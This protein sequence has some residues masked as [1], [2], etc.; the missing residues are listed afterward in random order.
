MRVTV[1]P[2]LLV[3]HLVRFRAGDP[4]ATLSVHASVV[5][6]PTPL[7]D[8]GY[9]TAGCADWLI[10]ATNFA[11]EQDGRARLLIYP[12]MSSTSFAW[13]EPARHYPPPTYRSFSKHG[14]PPG[15]P[16][17]DHWH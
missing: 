4:W 11:C 5:S 14:W 16:H 8:A 15:R 13:G 1:T 9:P 17:T 6:F 3:Q 2:T 7:D 10:Q 12:D